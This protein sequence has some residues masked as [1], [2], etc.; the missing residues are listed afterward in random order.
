MKP[1]SPWWNAAVIP[2][3]EALLKPH[4]VCFEW[5]SGRSTPWIAER[6]AH[7]TTVEHNDKW[8]RRIPKRENIEAHFLSLDGVY[9][10]A[11]DDKGMFDF[12]VVDGRKR[13]RCIQH[14]IPHVKIG[15]Y[16]ILDD[17]KRIRYRAGRRLLSEW[18]R[19]ICCEM[20]QEP[21]TIWIRRK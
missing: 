8:F 21:A 9:A 16:L 7:L 20:G 17:S 18:D 12:I 19:I 5:G 6:V 15:G 10:E 13:V 11:I 14:A 3:V 2:I 4:F 1:N